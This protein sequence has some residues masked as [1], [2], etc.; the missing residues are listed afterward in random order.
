ML[1]NYYPRRPTKYYYLFFIEHL[2]KIPAGE[3][4]LPAGASTSREQKNEPML[5]PIENP[6][7][8]PIQIKSQSFSLGGEIHMLADL[9]PPPST[10]PEDLVGQVQGMEPKLPLDANPPAYQMIPATVEES[11]QSREEPRRMERQLSDEGSL[12]MH[13]KYYIINFSLS[14]FM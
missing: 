11:L 5:G 3:P 12:S 13:I 9:E 10:T 6:D 4:T 8:K 7:T 14:H 1:Q 2:V